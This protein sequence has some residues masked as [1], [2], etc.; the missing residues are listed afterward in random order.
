M[1]TRLRHWPRPVAAEDTSRLL[2]E[3]RGEAWTARHRAYRSVPERPAIALAAAAAAAEAAVEAA[4]GAGAVAAA[5]Y[6]EAD[7]RLA[8]CPA[9]AGSYADASAVAASVTTG[10]FCDAAAAAEYSDP[11]TLLR[12][13]T[14]PTE[15]TRQQLLEVARIKFKPLAEQLRGET[16]SLLDRILPP[17]RAAA[18]RAKA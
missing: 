18:G 16:L 2:R 1:S 13:P 9:D 11:A 17:S 4:A 12:A 5:I 6:A 8:D 14:R 15:E 7:D 3:A 10:I